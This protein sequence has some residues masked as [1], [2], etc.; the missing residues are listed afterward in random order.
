[1]HEL[2]KTEEGV[3]ENVVGKGEQPRHWAAR[4]GLQ[5]TSE[6]VTPTALS[7]SSTASNRRR[8]STHVVYTHAHANATHNKDRLHVPRSVQDLAKPTS[9]PQILRPSRRRASQGRRAIWSGPRTQG[10][11]SHSEVG[12][13]VLCAT[14]S[15][16]ARS[17]TSNSEV[18]L[19]A[20]RTR[21]DLVPVTQRATIGEATRCQNFRRPQT[22]DRRLQA[23][24]C[25]CSPVM[26]GRRTPRIHRPLGKLPLH[27]HYAWHAV[28]GEMVCQQLT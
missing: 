24:G 26:E 9:S 4:R 17:L 12:V 14:I 6:P 18:C 5:H 10:S 27:V 23:A 15:I 21:L 3:E 7:M 19:F 2:T 1:M 22:A 25:T 13:S 28:S 20:W 8:G 16:R 11:P